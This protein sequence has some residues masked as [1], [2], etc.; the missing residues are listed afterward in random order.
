M[1]GCLRSPR[2][3][4]P[5]NDFE[6]WAVPAPCR[7]GR[8]ARDELERSVKDA[9]SALRYLLPERE[10]EEAADAIAESMFFALEDE[11]TEKLQRGPIL[12]ERAVK[13]GPRYGILAAIDLEAYTHVRGE[14][15]QILPAQA[16]DAEL[17]KACLALRE[18][19]PLEF[20]HAVVFYRDKKCKIVSRLLEEDLELLYDFDL[21]DGGGHIKGYFIPA[22]YSD[23][24]L[25][26]MHTRGEPCFAVAE[27]VEEIDAAKDYWEKLKPT[28]ERGELDGHPARFALVELQN[29]Y[30]EGVEIFPVH[31]LVCETDAPALIDYLSRKFKCK[32]EG[33][34]LSIAQRGTET[35]GA[36]DAALE[37]YLRQNGGRV[38][39]IYGS[40]EL[41]EAAKAEDT[42][43]ILLNTIDKE[44]IFSAIKGGKPL[45]KRTF[46]VGRAHEGRYLLEG[47]EI[48]YD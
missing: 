10:G 27:G 29:V 39:Y 16:G 20:P 2:V 1:R 17:N 6:K 31:R 47:R 13:G 48:G 37:E 23:W 46:A 12:V 19:A 45:P 14:T 5:R 26:E 38:R 35:A 21:A 30:E 15:A 7:I 3:L 28:L 8:A 44:D 11:W 43:G 18:K 33:N 4:I 32:R 40:A 42:V 22:P 36:C 25:D 41:K 9:P 34:I 24:A